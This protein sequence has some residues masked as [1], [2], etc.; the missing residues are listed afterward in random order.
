MLLRVLGTRSPYATRGKAGV[1]FLATINNKLVLLDC[2]AG[3]DANMSLP[4]EL[5]NLFVFITHL[6]ADHYAGLSS[7]QYASYYFH[8]LGRLNDKVQIYLPLFPMRDN[9]YIT[10]QKNSYCEYHDIMP[11]CLLKNDD[12]SIHASKVIHENIPSYMFSL[13]SGRTN[14]VYTGDMS[15]DSHDAA[16]EFAKNSDVLI[17]EASLLSKDAQKENANNHLTAI[18]AATIAKDANVGLLLLSHIWPEYNEDERLTEA[19]SIFKE[20]YIPHE[21]LTYGL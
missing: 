6:H 18:Q 17:A 19:R 3:T 7:I 9:D 15:Y 12:F 4:K 2:G 21:G 16:V 13:T 14:I 20:T 5:E 8:N 10:R 11:G 1:G